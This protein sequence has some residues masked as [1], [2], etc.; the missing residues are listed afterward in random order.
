MKLSDITIEKPKRQRENA[1][2]KTDVYNWLKRNLPKEE[3]VLYKNWGG[4]F[5][6][7][8]RPDIEITYKGLVN[9]WE[10]KDPGGSLSTLQVEVIKKYRAAGKIVFVAE[11]LDEFKTQWKS[12]Y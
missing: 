2:V 10:L 3:Y 7:A 5:G 6:R 12:I 8:G 4:G 1:G 11:S 9:Y